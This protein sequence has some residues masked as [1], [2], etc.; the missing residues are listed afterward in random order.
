MNI[1]HEK[2]KKNVDDWIHLYENGII[3][4]KKVAPKLFIKV[5]QFKV[6]SNDIKMVHR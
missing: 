6:I 1:L 4:R 2:K 3:Y 5:R